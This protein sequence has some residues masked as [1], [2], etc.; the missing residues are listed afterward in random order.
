MDE[1]KQREAMAGLE[2]LTFCEDASG[3]LL[4]YKYV[5]GRDVY[6]DLPTYESLDDVQRVYNT[7]SLEEKKQAIEWMGGGRRKFV[8]MSVGLVATLWEKPPAEWV[9][10]ILRAKGLWEEQP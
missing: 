1:H 2:G 5:N 10:A 9:E 6:F 4:A 3:K 8:T 7:L